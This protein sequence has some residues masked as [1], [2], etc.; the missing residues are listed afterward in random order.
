MRSRRG[1]RTVARGS[2]ARRRIAVCVGN[3]GFAA[4]LERRKLYQVLPDRE[5]EARELLRVV[6][7]SGED[8]LDPRR[9]FVELEVPPAVVRQLALAKR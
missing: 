1:H 8:D 3:R 6:D 2:R 5:A 7:E 4:S 9:F